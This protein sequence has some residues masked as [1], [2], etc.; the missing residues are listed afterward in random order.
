MTQG[1]MMGQ[2]QPMTQTRACEIDEHLYTDEIIILDMILV[3]LL[4]CLHL[5][6][7]LKPKRNSLGHLNVLLHTV[8]RASDL[9]IFMEH[10][11]LDIVYTLHDVYKKTLK[12]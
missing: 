6:V 10:A 4:C 11:I 1:H 3:V 5:K 12:C 7:F 2:M 9:F 8:R